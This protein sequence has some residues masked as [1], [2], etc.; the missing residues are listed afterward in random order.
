MRHTVWA[1]VLLSLLLVLLLLFTVGLGTAQEWSS[2]HAT[3][4]PSS[5]WSQALPV[6]NPYSDNPV[7]TF[8][9]NANAGYPGSDL[10]PREY[11]PDVP[12][13]GDDRSATLPPL[14]GGIYS[15]QPN[16]NCSGPHCGYSR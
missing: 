16:P 2:P 15:G 12:R 11:N 10:P 4:T 5:L 1:A 8:K 3:Y 14:D 7:H 13:Y 6:P 9:P